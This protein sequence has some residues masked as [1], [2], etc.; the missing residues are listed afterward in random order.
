MAVKTHETPLFP[1]MGEMLTME[2]ITA[3]LEE[4]AQ[5]ISELEA[6]VAAKPKA[7]SAGKPVSWKAVAEADY[8]AEGTP[9]GIL[10]RTKRENL[11]A[12]FSKVGNKLDSAVLADFINHHT[13]AFA[14]KDG[15]NHAEAVTALVTVKAKPRKE[16][17]EGGI[18]EDKTAEAPELEANED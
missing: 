10:H 17:T 8:A 13:E 1:F 5:K 18:V 16:K 4:Q 7:G 15:K 14:A 3:K 11:T 12:A 6:A 9:L 2:Q